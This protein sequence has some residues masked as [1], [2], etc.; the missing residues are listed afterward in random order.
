[1]SPS[2]VMKA[3]RRIAKIICATDSSLDACSY[4]LAE[5]HI[6]ETA[7]RMK[8]KQAWQIY[9]CDS[10][11]IVTK[12]CTLLD[13]AHRIGSSLDAAYPIVAFSSASELCLWLKKE[14]SRKEEKVPKPP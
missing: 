2:E 7:K 4:T 10:G 12:N 5:W 13:A 14:L 11:Y 9:I 6:R 1:M 8:K 3:K